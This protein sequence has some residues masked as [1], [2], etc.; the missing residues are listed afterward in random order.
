M[1]NHHDRL[2]VLRALMHSRGEEGVA[3]V[4][5]QGEISRRNES[6][7]YEQRQMPFIEQS[8]PLRAYCT[9]FIVQS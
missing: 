7:W 8:V 1:V 9:G 6:E 3:I 5:S 4:Q 2:I